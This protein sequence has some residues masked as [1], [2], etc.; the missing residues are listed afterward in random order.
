MELPPFVG[1]KTVLK[2]T[3]RELRWIQRL[4]SYPDDQLQAFGLKAIKKYSWYPSN[5]FATLM[6]F[7]KRLSNDEK[8][9]L[10]GTIDLR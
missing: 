3:A 5:E 9:Q 8:A 7:P 4:N 10:T 6:L 2:L 1:N